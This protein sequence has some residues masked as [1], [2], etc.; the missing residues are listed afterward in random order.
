[1]ILYPGD[2]AFELKATHGMPLDDVFHKIIVE[3]N[4]QLDWAGFIEAARRN[5]WWDFQTHEAI[6]VALE[7]AGVDRDTRREI[8]IR[9]RLYVVANPHQMMVG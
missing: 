7:E 1:M 3:H 9:F 4:L 8:L 5:G 6:Q 2:D